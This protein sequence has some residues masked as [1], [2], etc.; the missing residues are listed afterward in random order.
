MSVT[1]LVKAFLG[2][3]RSLWTTTTNRQGKLILSDTTENMVKSRHLDYELLRWTQPRCKRHKGQRWKVL[4]NVRI[5]YDDRARGEGNLEW[6]NWTLNGYDWCEG[7]CRTAPDSWTTAVFGL[8]LQTNALCFRRRN[9]DH[10][11]RIVDVNAKL[12]QYSE[13]WLCLCWNAHQ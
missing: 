8:M 13:Y 12:R 11:M 1:K 9:S 2:R 6:H 10:S 7:Q 3:T 5:W 4:G